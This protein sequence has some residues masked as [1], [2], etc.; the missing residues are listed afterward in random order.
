[1]GVLSLDAIIFFDAV[2]AIVNAL[3]SLFIDENCME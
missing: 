1:M 2:H 3:N